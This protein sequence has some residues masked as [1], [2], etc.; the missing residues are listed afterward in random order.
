[1]KKRIFAG[2]LALLM[3]IGLLPVSSMVKKPMEVKAEQKT[4]T[5]STEA[6]SYGDTTNTTENEY[7]IGE[8]AY[9]TAVV[10][11][12]KVFMCG[13]NSDS[14]GDKNNSYKF[15]SNGYAIKFN[16]NGTS[17]VVTVKWMVSS[18]NRSYGIQLSGQL[19]EGQSD[20][21]TTNTAKELQTSTFKVN[22]GEHKLTRVDGTV[23]VFSM[24]V[25]ETVEDTSGY[26]VTVI[27]GD[28]KTTATYP[29]GDTLKLSAKGDNFLYWVNSNGVKV[30]ESPEKDIP[31]YYSDTY[32][33]VYA[34]SD[35][36]VE[37]MTPYGGVLATYFTDDDFTE[38]EVPTRYGYTK[39]SW[40][41][42]VDTVKAA[43]AKGESVTVKPNYKNNEGLSYTITIDKTDFNEG[44]SGG[45][46]TV[47]TVVNASVTDKTNF[48][49]WTDGTNIV[50]YNPE[51]YFFANRKVTIKAV[52]K[53]NATDV[54]A[55]GVITQ[56]EY[57]EANRT[58]IFEYTVPDD[59]TMNYVGVLGSTN[60]S[61][62]TDGVVN[63]G[64]KGLYQSG[65]NSCS[66]YKTYRY[67]VNIVG[68]E[69]WYV[70]PVLTYT[71]TNGTQTT[72]YGNKVTIK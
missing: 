44:T 47:N 13:S 43:L 60:E 61:I 33:A 8:D 3:I 18:K 5:L 29:E 59:F 28:S 41:M 12:K 35:T 10:P 14:T 49:Y 34:K 62:L 27:D 63:S 26:K 20:N 58:V 32:T 56:V 15:D 17:A 51:Y 39:D 31:V 16:V 40:D 22:S 64:V 25:V 57:N 71:D 55:K 68:S 24:E 2:A 54:N 11:A 52:N 65:D 66:Q 38:P 7:S 45:T 72:I 46:Y 67:T 36:K 48:A 69:T 37:Y 42:D 19:A 4:Y 23:Y 50:S 9:F 53:D 21:Y 70:K 6:K 1:M 30:S